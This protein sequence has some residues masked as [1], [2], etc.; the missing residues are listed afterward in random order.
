M[1]DRRHFVAASAGVFAGFALPG[2]V[3]AQPIET[4]RILVGFPPGGTVDA[5]ARRKGTTAVAN[6]YLEYLYGPEAQ[7]LI[8]KNHYRPSD[9]EVLARHRAEFADLKLIRIE[10]V[11]GGWAAAQAKFFNEGG[12]FDQIYQ[13][14]R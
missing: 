1:L 4:A 3:S 6:A 7:E 2:L 14:G 10:D 13:P 8:A 9:P 11:F 5:V 12:V